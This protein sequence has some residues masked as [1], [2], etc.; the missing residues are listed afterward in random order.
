MYWDFPC[1]GIPLGMYLGIPL[2]SVILHPPLLWDVL[3]VGDCHLGIPLLSV[4]LHVLV[5]TDSGNSQ[6]RLPYPGYFPVYL[7]DFLGDFLFL[8]ISRDD[9]V[10]T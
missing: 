6:P 4:I 2:F 1:A 10:I 8:R 7:R 9:D 3:G 5:L